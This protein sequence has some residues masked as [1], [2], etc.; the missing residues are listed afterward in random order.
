MA[1]LFR[2]HNNVPPGPQANEAAAPDGGPTVTAG[3]RQRHQPG[4][5]ARRRTRRPVGRAHSDSLAALRRRHELVQAARVM[6]RLRRVRPLP[7]RA[8]LDFRDHALAN[9]RDG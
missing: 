6:T 2:R 9:G 1:K 5:G 7:A 8:T 4:G 3:A